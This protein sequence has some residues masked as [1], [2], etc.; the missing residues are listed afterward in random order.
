MKFAIGLIPVVFATYLA[1]A[2]DDYRIGSLNCAGTREGTTLMLE[3][4][5]LLVFEKS[6]R[7]NEPK[8]SFVSDGAESFGRIDYLEM[9]LKYK[10]TKYKDFY[11]FNLTQMTDVQ[12]FGRFLPGDCD[13]KVMIPKT[14]G[15][16]ANFDAPVQYSCEQSGGVLTMKCDFKASQK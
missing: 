9:D 8:A 13:I 16:T 4:K 12:T 1:F 15:T 6:A 14:A 10:G 7:M 3:A 2:A 11:R 5:A